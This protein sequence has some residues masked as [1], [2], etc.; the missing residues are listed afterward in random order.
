MGLPVEGSKRPKGD[1]VGTFL[2][3]A[4]R[5]ALDETVPDDLMELLRKL[6]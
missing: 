5:E 4:Y 3:E 2:R 1:D 6:D